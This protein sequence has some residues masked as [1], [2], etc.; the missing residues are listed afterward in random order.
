MKQKWLDLSIGQKVIFCLQLVLI[1][2]FLILYSTVGKQQVLRY[3]DASLRRTVEGDTVTYAGKVEG[4]S[5]SFSVSGTTVEYRQGKNTITYT[6][7]ED[8][9][10]IPAREDFEFDSDVMY[11]KLS[12]VEIRKNGELL[13]RGGWIPFSSS[14]TLYNEDGSSSFTGSYIVHSYSGAVLEDPGASTILRILYQ[15]N[16]T[17]R[18]NFLGLFGGILL[19]IATMV[20]LL[21]ADALF[22]W[23]LSFSIRNA[24]HAEPT[25][26]EICSRWM[27]WLTFT[28]LAVVIF[29]MGLTGM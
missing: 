18:A 27:G 28:C 12:G 5:V 11:A 19:C 7:T 26:W 4:N 24:E 15:P 2:L 8:P 14:L 6:V 10:A 9:S 1:V 16:V 20:T 29:I 22:R 21:F 25:E 17:Q 3:H 13:F 23:N